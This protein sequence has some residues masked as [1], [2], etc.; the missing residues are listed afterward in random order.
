MKGKKLYDLIKYHTL[1]DSPTQED[2]DK[3]KDI[4]FSGEVI[5][6]NGLGAQMRFPTAN[7]Q[8]I[9][10]DYKQIGSPNV[11]GN[12]NHLNFILSSEIKI[13]GDSKT[14]SGIL[15]VEYDYDWSELKESL[16]NGYKPEENSYIVV[17]EEMGEFYISDGSHRHEILI[18]SM[19][20]ENIDVKTEDGNIISLKVKDIIH[21]HA[22]AHENRI[23]AH[24]FDFSGDIYGKNITAYPKNKVSEKVFE[25]MC[26]LRKSLN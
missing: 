18:H 26:Q 12:K 21:N 10:S 24:I 7:F 5:N 6:G 19:P 20:N 17:R 1:K 23:S 13:D 25:Y 4:S 3:Y 8:V 11:E 2:E 9:D 14:Y 16:K 15:I 22:H